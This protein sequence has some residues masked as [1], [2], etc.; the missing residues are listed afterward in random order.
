MSINIIQACADAKLFGPWFKKRESWATWFVFLKA[1]FGLPMTDA[2]QSVFHQL[3]GR[4]EPPTQQAAEAWLVIGRRG[5][6]SFIVAL[7]AVFL[8]CFRDYTQHLAPGERGTVMV[9]AADR[10]Q[11]RVI[12][13][14]VKGLLEGVPMLR[15]MIVAQRGEAIEL[16]NR[17]DIEIHTGSFRAVRGYTVVAALLDEVAFWRSEESANPDKEI[18]NALRP[19]MATIPN[20]LL[21][22][23]SSPYARRG[24]LYEAW[25][26]HYGKP[27]DVLVIQADSRTMNP[28]LPQSVVDRAYAEDPASAAAEYGALFRSDVEGFLQP[29][30]IDRAVETGISELPP[31]PGIDYFAFADPSGGASDSFTLGIAH[32]EGERRILDVCRGRR[33]PFDPK[34]V[35]NDYAD[36]LRRYGCGRVIGDRYAAEWVVSAFREHG[37]SYDPAELPKSDIYL[38]AEPLFATGA[39]QLLDQR[40]LLT[41]LRQLERRTGSGKD[42]IDHPPRGHDDLANAACGALWLASRR[43]AEVDM[44]DAQVDTPEDRQAA[45]DE[46]MAELEQQAAMHRWDF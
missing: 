1:L 30:W 3:T 17:I 13:R 33:P 24:V 38:N 5:G 43:R 18:V 45:T 21:I 14:Y 46:R 40:Q 12:M 4:T 15:R 31:I 36:I 2:E 28:S 34:A 26:Q 42:R 19:A 27:S 6:K 23:L 35:T 44:S 10:K 20:S 41:E 7:I 29:E 39:V 25:A 9:I 37:I 16:S 32:R 22:G 8:A 11:A